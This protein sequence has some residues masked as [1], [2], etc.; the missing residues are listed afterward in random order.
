M[1]FLHRLTEPVFNV[2]WAMLRRHQEMDEACDK[3]L[4]FVPMP[5]D[6]LIVSNACPH[7]CRWT[8]FKDLC[9]LVDVLRVAFLNRESLGSHGRRNAMLGCWWEAWATSSD[10]ILTFRIKFVMKSRVF[11]SALRRKSCTGPS[12]FLRPGSKVDPANG[13][14]IQGHVCIVQ[15]LQ[16]KTGRKHTQL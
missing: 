11:D 14:S 8:N 16:S 6:H 5:F 15:V 3:P 12:T 2:E 9:T 1:A 10:F 7:L 13:N 4:I